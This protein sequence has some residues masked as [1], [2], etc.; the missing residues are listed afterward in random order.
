[1]K[2]WHRQIGENNRWYSRFRD[3]F[4]VQGPDRSLD[5]AFRLWQ[6]SVGRSSVRGKAT[7]SWLKMAKQDNWRERA[8][9]WDEEQRQKAFA[10]VEDERTDMLKRHI[11]LGIAIQNA[12]LQKLR[13]IIGDPQ[14]GMPG[15]WDTLSPSQVL[16]FLEKGVEIERQARGE[17]SDHIHLSGQMLDAAIE[18]E[19]RKLLEVRNS[20]DDVLPDEDSDD[21]HPSEL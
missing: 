18:S 9:Q 1:M 12:A 13:R 21:L 16:A 7:T 4:M 6:K 14:S 8:A 20:S 10:S 5:E 15:E 2:P 17:P 11:Q 3:F 19:L